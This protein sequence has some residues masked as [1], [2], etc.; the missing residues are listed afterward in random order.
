MK[1]FLVSLS[2]LSVLQIAWLGQIFVQGKQ[3]LVKAGFL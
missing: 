3:E 1:F 2:G